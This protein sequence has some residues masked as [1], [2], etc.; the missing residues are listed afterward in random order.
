MMKKHLSGALFEYQD[1]RTPGELF[2]N[3]DGFIEKK[4]TSTIR[5]SLLIG[6]VS[7]AALLLELFPR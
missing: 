6:Y 2:D 7:P 1:H 5:T 3:I 4:D